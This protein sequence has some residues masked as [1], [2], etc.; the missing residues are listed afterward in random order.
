MAKATDTVAGSVATAN[1][2]V[3]GLQIGPIAVPGVDL[4]A[5]TNALNNLLAQVEAALGTVLGPLGLGELLSVKLFDR[6]TGVTE[7]GGVV[8]AVSSITGLVV[9]LTPPSAGLL[10]QLTQ[11]AG[12]LGAIL[13]GT[14]ARTS[15]GGSV[16]AAATAPALAAAVPNPLEAVLGVTSVLSKGLELRVGTVQSQSLHGGSAAIPLA[17]GAPTPATTTDGTL[18]RTGGEQTTL[19]LLA[20]GLAAVALGARCLRRRTGS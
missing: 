13:G 12:G 11:P 15:G 14:A 6:Q 7:A 18:P 3:G 1:G 2:K 8:K 16:A 9:K 5:A 10:G 19:A 17:P 4:L 20:M